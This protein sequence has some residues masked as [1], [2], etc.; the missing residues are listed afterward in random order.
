MP[1]KYGV[2][3]V[4]IWQGLGGLDW[5][6]PGTNPAGIRDNW[7]LSICPSIFRKLRDV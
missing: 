3:L 5:A 1:T 4:E 6:I 2:P 7:D